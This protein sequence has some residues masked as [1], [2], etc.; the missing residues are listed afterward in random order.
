MNRTEL[1]LKV[2]AVEQSESKRR[3][4][5][6]RMRNQSDFTLES[7]PWF[8]ERTV[9]SLDLQTSTLGPSFDDNKNG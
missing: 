5:R 1:N 6:G 8:L 2:A 4:R 9:S 7:L 3:E